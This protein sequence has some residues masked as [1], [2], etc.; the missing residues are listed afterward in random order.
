VAAEAEQLEETAPGAEPP[1]TE[2][3]AGTGPADVQTE[4]E[5]SGRMEDAGSPTHNPSEGT[6]P[7]GTVL[8]EGIPESSGE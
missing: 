7:E 3:A 2:H 5:E 4:A 8:E 1:E 6:V